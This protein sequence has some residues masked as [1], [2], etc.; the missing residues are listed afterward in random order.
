VETDLDPKA[1][2][3]GAKKLVRIGQKYFKQAG[4]CKF[5]YA[6]AKVKRLR[7]LY[8]ELTLLVTVFPQQIEICGDDCVEVVTKDL[9]SQIRTL[10]DEISKLAVESQY[11]G[12]KFCKNP[13]PGVRKTAPIV[14]ELN[15]NIDLCPTHVCPK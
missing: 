6:G 3:N 10:T 13:K 7:T 2:L 5:K 1:I 12:R 11:T 14:D 4:S 8:K 9:L 15:R